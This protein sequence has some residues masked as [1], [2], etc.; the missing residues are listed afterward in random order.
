MKVQWKI[1]WLSNGSREQKKQKR[2]IKFSH[3]RKSERIST[4][5][6]SFSPAFQHIFS[7]VGERWKL[8]ARNLCE[9]KLSRSL[10]KSIL[11]SFSLSSHLFLSIVLASLF[12]S[13]SNFQH[14][15]IRSQESGDLRSFIIYYIFHAV[16]V[17]YILYT[18]HHFTSILIDFPGLSLFS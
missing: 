12:L 9:K 11:H 1:N 7:R 4:Y 16:Y 13:I 2:Q 14:F 6:F 8:R 18:F 5:I 15:L 17:Y 3:L 10:K